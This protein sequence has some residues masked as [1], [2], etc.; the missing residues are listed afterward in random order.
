M[1]VLLVS[2]PGAG[3]PAHWSHDVAATLAAVLQRAAA[4]VHWLAVAHGRQP[5]APAP[6]G[7]AREILPMPRVRPAHVADANTHLPVELALT[8][9][10]RAAPAAVVVHVGLGAGGSPNVPWLADRLGAP[11]FVIARAAE[12]ACHRADLLPGDDAPCGEAAAGERCLRCCPRGWRYRGNARALLARTDLLA[13]S[14]LASTALF[15]PGEAHVAPLV[16]LGVP[17]RTIV[18]G[19]APHAVAAR[20]LGVHA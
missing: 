6:P 1:R 10:L 19:T 12:V 2:S 9:R 5:L 4:S 8:A 11:A 13:A 20:L 16:A 17:R 7:V 15:V 14:L 3:G 18:V